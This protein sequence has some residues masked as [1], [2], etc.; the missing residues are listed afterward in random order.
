MAIFGLGHKTTEKYVM[1]LA[2]A[3]IYNLGSERKKCYQ[4]TFYPIHFS[5]PPPQTV[6]EWT[7]S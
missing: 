2:V 7:I 6:P 1:K 5:L 4:F 3:R